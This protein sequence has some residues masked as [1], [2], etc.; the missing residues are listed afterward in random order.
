M[1]ATTGYTDWNAARKLA[2]A[3]SACSKRAYIKTDKTFAVKFTEIIADLR[4]NQPLL[5]PANVAYTATGLNSTFNRHMDQVL[6]KLGVSSE[7]VNLSGLPENP[8]EYDTLMLN[9]ASEISNRKQRVQKSK[10]EDAKAAKGKLVHEAAGLKF[11]ECHISAS[12]EVCEGRDVKGLYAKARAGIIPKFTGV[13]DPYEA[14]ASPALNIDTGSLSLDAC[15]TKVINHMTSEG[16]LRN[17][18]TR[19]VAESMWRDASADEA[20]EFAGLPV[21]DIDQHQVE[22]LQTIGDGWAAPLKR[23]MNELELLEVMN[24]KTITDGEGK[25]HLL[26]VPIT[27]SV[28]AEQKASFEGK[29]KIAIK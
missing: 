6:E 13:S 8:G 20:T 10:E 3:R 4:A 17:N 19:V 15:Q 21:L 16:V 9:M 7:C 2:L 29:T 27:Q 23:F 28:T 11:Y 18:N 1:E 24:M 12:L 25:R 5:F 14:P 26:S 22:Y